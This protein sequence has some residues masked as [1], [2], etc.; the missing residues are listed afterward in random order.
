[1]VNKLP[2]MLLPVVWCAACTPQ[3]AEEHLVVQGLL[4]R[5]SITETG[6]AAVS[7]DYDSPGARAEWWPCDLRITAQGCIDGAHVN[8]YVGLPAV[9]TLSDLGQA[10][11]VAQGAAQGVYELL[12]NS[13]GLGAY[14]IGSDLSA[15]ILIASDRDDV[16][17]ADL[18]SDAETVAATK[19][20]GGTFFVDAWGGVTGFGAT[21]EAT[22]ADGREVRA[23]FQGPASSTDV[24]P[25]EPPQTCVARDG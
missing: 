22:T 14:S 20:T 16:A 24:F 4:D 2:R 19:L 8:L 21:L 5:N 18:A 25:I 1:M 23:Q 10:S 13:G 11:C 7:V 6:S 12:A 15:F 3:V 17:G 9:A